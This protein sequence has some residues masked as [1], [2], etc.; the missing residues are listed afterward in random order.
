MEKANTGRRCYGQPRTENMPGNLSKEMYL[1]RQLCVME[2]TKKKLK[3]L[4]K[5]ALMF[6]KI[7]LSNERELTVACKNVS[8]VISAV[9]GLHDVIVELQTELLKAAIAAY[10]PRFIPS[11]FSSDFT[12]MPQGENRNF[13]LRKEFHNKLDKKLDPDH[14]YIQ[15]CLCRHS[16][17]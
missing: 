5:W 9:A 1:L 3:P 15:R 16:A 12:M 2:A 11:D 6:F 13:D 10:V 17:I 4:K 7:D 8:C 14:L